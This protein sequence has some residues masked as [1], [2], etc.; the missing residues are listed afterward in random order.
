MTL[1]IKR[2]SEAKMDLYRSLIDK[3]VQKKSALHSKSDLA[4]KINSVQ[5]NFHKA[6]SEYAK[7]NGFEKRTPDES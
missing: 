7:Q 4:K 1:D 3:A 5:E 6:A 2:D